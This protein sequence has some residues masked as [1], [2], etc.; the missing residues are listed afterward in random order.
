MEN[1]P[2]RAEFWKSFVL[3]KCQYPSPNLLRDQFSHAEF[4]DFCRCGCN[5]FGMR[6]ESAKAKP[7]L[8]PRHDKRSGG[9]AAIY[10]AEFR[11]PDEKT[12]EIIIFADDDG[13]LAGVDVDYCGNSYPVPDDV[14][15][16][17]PP[18]HTWA[19]KSLFRES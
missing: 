2:A 10:T 17:E 16:E 19:A 18:F 6:V 5:S 3:D 12:L 14:T 15:V 9:H 4:T 8:P 11:L 7:L 13:Y 1:G